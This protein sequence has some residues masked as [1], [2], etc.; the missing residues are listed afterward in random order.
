MTE[1]LPPP[2]L[3]SS[4]GGAR[5]VVEPDAVL[6]AAAQHFGAHASLDMDTLAAELNISRATLYRLAGSRDELLAEVFWLVARRVFEAAAAAQP[7]V[8]GAD[9][10]IG[11]SR[12]YAALLSGG[13][14]LRKFYADEPQTATRLLFSPVHAVHLRSVA[15]QQEVFATAGVLTGLSDDEARARA[16][17]YVRVME[18]VM[19]GDLLGTGQIDFA[20]AEPILRS[21]MEGE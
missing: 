7:S 2:E 11:L 9:G 4:A 15:A 21:L 1:G 17:L 16:A 8:R 20:T 18:S 14:P 13:I 6:R 3:R 19:F 5:R 10:V 12:S